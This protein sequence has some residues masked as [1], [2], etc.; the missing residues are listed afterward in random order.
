[1]FMLDATPERKQAVDFPEA[2]LLWYALAV[3]AKEELGI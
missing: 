2:P 1:M 3:L